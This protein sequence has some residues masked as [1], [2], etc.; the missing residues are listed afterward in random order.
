MTAWRLKFRK[1]FNSRAQTPSQY[2]PSL[3][4]WALASH[5][6]DTFTPLRNFWPLPYLIPQFSN[7]T[8][9]RNSLDVFSY[10]NKKINYPHKQETSDPGMLHF[11]I[12]CKITLSL[13]VYACYFIEMIILNLQ[14]V[15]L[16]KINIFLTGSGYHGNCNKC[17]IPD[18]LACCQYRK[19][20]R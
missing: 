13:V 12:I 15:Y 10:F 9:S 11:Q 17:T 2:L 18:V 19:R 14:L 6:F 5:L 16:D 7:N 3:R 8:Y 4:M 20:Q 1:K